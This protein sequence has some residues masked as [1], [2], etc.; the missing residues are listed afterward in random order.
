VVVESHWDVKKE[1][2]SQ[3]TLGRGGKHLTESQEEKSR[4]H[5]PMREASPDHKGDNCSTSA[6]VVRR[7]LE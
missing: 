1:E 7:K 6:T 5:T 4:P 2:F 3:Q